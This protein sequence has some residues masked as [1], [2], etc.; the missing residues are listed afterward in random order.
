MSED[1]EDQ[2]VWMR[3]NDQNIE[4]TLIHSGMDSTNSGTWLDNA[5]KA[6][7]LALAQ[8]DTLAL[9][10]EIKGGSQGIKDITFCITLT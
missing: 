9:Y 1:G 5:S 2:R 4:E 8:G 7:F 6:M 3:K 10:H